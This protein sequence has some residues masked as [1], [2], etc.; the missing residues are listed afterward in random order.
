MTAL[1]LKKNQKL[2]ATW[3]VQQMEAGLR[4]D[5]KSQ[6][7]YHPNSLKYDRKTPISAGDTIKLKNTGDFHRSVVSK[8]KAK[9]DLIE[10]TGDFVKRTT[11]LEKEFEPIFG[12]TESNLDKMVDITFDDLVKGLR[13]YW[14]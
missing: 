9:K 5:G 11:D 3:N 2:Y 10:F 6:P 13:A 12:L 4:S 14:K 1:S 8:T 7:K